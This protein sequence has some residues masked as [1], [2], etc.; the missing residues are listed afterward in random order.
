MMLQAK[1]KNQAFSDRENRKPGL[2][3]GGELP[4]GYSSGEDPLLG[5]YVPKRLTEAYTVMVGALVGISAVPVLQ[6]L[7]EPPA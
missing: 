4:N 5:G 6:R 3:S 1:E 7:K 2:Q